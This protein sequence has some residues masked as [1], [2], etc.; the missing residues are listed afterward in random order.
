MGMARP[1][2]NVIDPGLN[3]GPRAIRCVSIF[4]IE[5]NVNGIIL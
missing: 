1:C 3:D 5:N 2:Y 4:S